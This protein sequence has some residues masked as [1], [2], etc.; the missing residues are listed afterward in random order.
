MLGVHGEAFLRAVIEPP[1][2]AWLNETRT[3]LWQLRSALAQGLRQLGLEVQ[4]SQANFLL[5]R[6]GQAT[7][8]AQKLRAKGLR[9]RDC[10]SFGLLEW[11]R[12]SAQKPLA[13]TALLQAL[14]AILLA[15]P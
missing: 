4:E 10:T 14:Q 8:I 15:R 2:Q 13:Q 3:K 7:Q 11:L 6:V 1:S 12:L 5:V 9:V